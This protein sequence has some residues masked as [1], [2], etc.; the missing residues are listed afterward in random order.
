MDA[1]YRIHAPRTVQRQPRHVEQAADRRGTPEVEEALHRD[2]QLADEIA[3]VRNHQVMGERVVACRD[4]R[5]SRKYTIGRN[6]FERNAERQPFAQP[7]TQQLQDQKSGVSLVQVPHRRRN[8]QRT[9]GACAADAQND[10]LPDASGL[11]A[12]VEPMRDVAIRRRVRRAV[13]IEQV[14]GNAPDLRLPKSRDHVPAGNPH[15]D[16]NPLSVGSPSR[17]NGQVARVALA[18]FRVLV[19]VVVD[20]LS[21]VAL[22]VEETNGDEIRTGVAGRFAVVTGEHTQATG[23]NLKA[24]VKAVL[25]AEVRHQ[26]GIRRGRSGREVG[27]QR[28]PGLVVSSQVDR[29]LGGPIECALVDTAK[30]EPGV[31]TRLFP[32]LRIQV[33]EQRPGGAMPAE[34]QVAGQ[35]GQPAQAVRDD[36]GDLK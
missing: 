15:T 31:A 11:I 12:A 27:I 1:A 30:H 18:V 14:N 26:R 33:L 25:S 23:V 6:R 20:G 17:L 34:E 7:L 19:T 8:T 24:F 10:L 5:M 2:A 28:V 3:K 35:L 29:I 22:F 16:L 36:R 32:Q 21:E 9:Q 4:R 13:G